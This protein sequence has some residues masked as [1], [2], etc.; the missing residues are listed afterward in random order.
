[1]TSITGSISYSNI[2]TDGRYTVLEIWTD[3]QGNQYS[4]SYMSDANVIDAQ[5]HDQAL[6]DATA[7]QAQQDGG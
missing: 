3:D 6:A 1:M 5:K 2:Q 7:N 4:Y